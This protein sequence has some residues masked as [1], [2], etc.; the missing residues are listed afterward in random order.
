MFDH[1]IRYKIA[2]YPIQSN[3]TPTDKP[4]LNGKGSEESEDNGGQSLPKIETVGW[5]WAS[6]FQGRVGCC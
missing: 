3:H 1:R 6:A 2:S 4:P 5:E